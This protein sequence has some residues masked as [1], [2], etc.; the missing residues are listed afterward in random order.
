M[1]TDHPEYQGLLAD[2][3]SWPEEDGPR[4]IMADWLSDHGEEQ[5]AEFI[6]AHCEVARLAMPVPED[7]LQEFLWSDESREWKETC[8]VLRHRCRELLPLVMP[9]EVSGLYPSDW[10]VT[11]RTD[12]RWE[13]V[14][15]V[16]IGPTSGKEYHRNT[17]RV[18]RGFIDEVKYPLWAWEQY[19]PFI[20]QRQPVTKVSVARK[21]PDW[22]T[23]SFV[24]KPCS[25][26]RPQECVTQH[27]ISSSIH[28][29]LETS[30]W[31]TREAAKA[32]L[33]EAC[34]VYAGKRIAEWPKA[35]LVVPPLPPGFLT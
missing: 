10:T 13:W 29:L 9:G 23:G 1:T 6:R 3:L 24:W 7:L 22:L 27:H 21:E 14:E 31:P 2:V 28:S 30:S 33:S 4:L 35:P 17:F 25:C 11:S 20:I 12:D 34:L 15:T 26:V 16:T 18:R 19:G 8:G 5:R 32:G